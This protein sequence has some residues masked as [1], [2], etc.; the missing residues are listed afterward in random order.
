LDRPAARRSGSAHW[1]DAD[2]LVAL[3]EAERMRVDRIAAAEVFVHQRP[4]TTITGG[5]GG[6]PG[7]KVRPATRVMPSALKSGAIN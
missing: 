6:S 4:F 5:A 1:N 2:D 3:A 7:L